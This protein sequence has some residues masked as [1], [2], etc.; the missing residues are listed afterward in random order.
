MIIGVTPTKE[1]MEEIALDLFVQC[2]KFECI[3]KLE[4]P[5]IEL[6]MNVL[7]L[8]YGVQI[9]KNEITPENVKEGW[10]QVIEQLG[11]AQMLG[12][13]KTYVDGSREL[14]ESE[15]ALMEKA[16]EKRKRKEERKLK[17][18]VEETIKE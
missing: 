1:Q 7:G 2:V 3:D 12:V 4:N 8:I 18:L 10:K 11:V 14:S 6:K 16:D 13:R 15:L 17:L 9:P 5:F